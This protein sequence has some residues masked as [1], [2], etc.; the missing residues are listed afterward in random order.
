MRLECE[1]G[2]AV[3]PFREKN[4]NVNPACHKIH[5]GRFYLLI[6]SF[7]SKMFIFYCNSLDQGNAFSVF[8]HNDR[9]VAV[10]FF[11]ISLQILARDWMVGEIAY[12]AIDNASVI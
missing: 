1:I 8:Y 10:S 3:E 11:R 4:N 12:N 2:T 5:Q 7:F 9:S 6:V